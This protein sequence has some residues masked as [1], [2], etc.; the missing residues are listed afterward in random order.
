VGTETWSM[1]PEDYAWQNKA[2]S[3]SGNRQALPYGIYAGTFSVAAGF[4]FI[5]I[6]ATRVLGFVV[7]MESVYSTIAIAMPATLPVKD[8]S[9]AVMVVPKLAPSMATFS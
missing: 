6:L 7:G 1:K 4:L 9:I 8:A 2:Q 5:E 3:S